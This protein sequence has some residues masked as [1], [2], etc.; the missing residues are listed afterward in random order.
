MGDGFATEGL[1]V[2]HGKQRKQKMHV[3][4]CWLP[5][6]DWIFFFDTWFSMWKRVARCLPHAMKIPHAISD[7]VS[8]VGFS[9]QWSGVDNAL[10]LLQYY[11]RS[12]A[13]RIPTL[14][15][16]NLWRTVHPSSSQR[17]SVFFVI[18][19]LLSN[20][21]MISSINNIIGTRVL[22]CTLQQRKFR[23]A[24]TP[25]ANLH[26]GSLSYSCWEGNV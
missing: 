3:M 6:Y 26:L 21:G 23:P 8:A 19:K 18:K 20:W 1:V 24:T 10:R 11:N 22:R 15:S 4:P 12:D 17:K 9:A 25:V 16:R 5:G 14:C 13:W 2:R 7:E